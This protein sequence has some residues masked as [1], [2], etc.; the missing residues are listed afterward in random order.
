LTRAL[1]LDDKQT[2]ELKQL[3]AK[4]EKREKKRKKKTGIWFYIKQLFK[5]FFNLF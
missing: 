2:K 1:E 3:F 4:W 5:R